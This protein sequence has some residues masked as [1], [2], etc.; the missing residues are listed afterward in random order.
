[1]PTEPDTSVYRPVDV[2][3]EIS[4]QHGS[5]TLT[6]VGHGP[7]IVVRANSLGVAIQPISWLK[8]QQPGLRVPL[9]Q[10]GSVLNTMGLTIELRVGEKLHARLGA[11]AHSSLLSWF[12]F[13]NVECHTFQIARRFWQGHF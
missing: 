3:G 6:I 12:G 11:D 8:R 7:T 4:L 5:D 1:M 9:R 10:I 2:E 13:R